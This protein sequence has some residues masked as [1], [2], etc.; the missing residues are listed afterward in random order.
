VSISIAD[1]VV[2]FDYGEVISNEPSPEAR[3][4]LVRLAGVPAERFWPAYWQHRDDL[5]RGTLTV[6]EYWAAIAAATDAAFPAARVH[7]LYVAD[8]TS[9]IQVNPDVVTIIDE[10]VEGH[11]RVALLSNAAL[12]YGDHFR[13][14]PLGQYFERVFVSAEMGMLKPQPEIYR[15][16]VAELGIDAADVV[17]ID[18]KEVNIE[19]ARAVGLTGHVFHGAAELRTFLEELSA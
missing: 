3:G 12:D 14:S 4:E 9:W 1:R 18:N 19:G 11:T 15:A 5:D 17:F 7:E 16:V 8:F 6:V 13:F 2:L 10:L